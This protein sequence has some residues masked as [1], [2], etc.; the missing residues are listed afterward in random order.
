MIRWNDLMGCLLGFVC[1]STL[2]IQIVEA[3]GSALTLRKTPV[4]QTQRRGRTNT[5]LAIVSVYH[6]ALYEE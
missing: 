2:E 6:I 5:T 4:R 1:A 3:F